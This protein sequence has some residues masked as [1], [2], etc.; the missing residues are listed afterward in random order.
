MGPSTHLRGRSHFIISVC[1]LSPFC[2]LGQ[3]GQRGQTVNSVLPSL[4]STHEINGWY[5]VVKAK[6]RGHVDGEVQRWEAFF[7]ETLAQLR[8]RLA[9]VALQCNSRTPWTRKIWIHAFHLFSVRGVLVLFKER[10]TYYHYKGGLARDST[11]LVVSAKKGD[12]S[13]W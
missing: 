9:F 1:L 3:K 11:G 8:T 12:V 5:L 7:T 6:S 2:A 10:G 4:P 13:R